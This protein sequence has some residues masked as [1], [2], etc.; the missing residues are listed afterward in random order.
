[1]TP[2][3]DYAFVGDPPLI[4]PEA[5]E[6]HVDCT[7][8]WDIPEARRLEAAWRQYYMTKIG[9][10]A[11]NDFGG[12]FTPGLYV[13]Q[14]VTFT[15]RGCNNRCPWCLAWQREGRFREIE[16][17]PGNNILDNNILQCSKEHWSE[18]VDMLR[19]QRGVRFSGGLDSRELTDSQADDLRTLSIKHLFFACDTKEAIKPLERAK[20]RLEGFTMSELRAY[21]LIAFNNETIDQAQARLIEVYEL[22]FM[23]FAQLYQPPDDHIKYSREWRELARVWTRPAIAKA[24]MRWRQHGTG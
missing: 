22:G 8:T 20:R 15:S 9:G 21:V 13:R 19:S 3:D 1:M 23:P 14:G 2:T 11:N 7:F 4:R 18:V 24:Y 12:Q 5:T 6:V 10:A 17:H 16:I